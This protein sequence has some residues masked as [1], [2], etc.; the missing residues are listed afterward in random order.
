MTDGAQTE[1]GNPFKPADKLKQRGFE[2]YSVA[3]GDA[4]RYQSQLERLKN[5]DLFTVS[6]ASDMTKLVQDVAQAICPSK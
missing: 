1:P 4:K 2:I 6:R 3:A 5:R